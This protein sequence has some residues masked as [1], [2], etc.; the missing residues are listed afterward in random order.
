MNFQKEQQKNKKK[1]S[2]VTDLDITMFWKECG[3]QW[4]ELV[5]IDA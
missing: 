1:D 4:V 2:A 5:V 3:M